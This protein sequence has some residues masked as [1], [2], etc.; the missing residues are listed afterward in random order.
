MD[1]SLPGSS[2]QGILQARILAFPSFSM[3]SS[4]PR[5]WTQV[6]HW[7]IL[8]H[9]SHQ[10]SP[11]MLELVAYPFFKR[12]SQP[13]NQIKVSQVVSLPVELQRW[14][15]TKIQQIALSCQWTTKTKNDTGK[16]H[17]REE[18]KHKREESDSERS[19]KVQFPYYS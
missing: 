16:W 15:Q 2:V 4:Q 19:K 11:R 9:L 17:I 3:G 7:Q 18:R 12:Y 10:G 8:Y 1:C 14:T 6:S 13:R 5:E